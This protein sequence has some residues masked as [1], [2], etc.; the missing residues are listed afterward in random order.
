MVANQVDVRNLLPVR[1][2]N[3]YPVDIKVGATTF[4]DS[5]NVMPVEVLCRFKQCC[6]TRSPIARPFSR[7]VPVQASKSAS[8]AVGGIR[9]VVNDHAVPILS[10]LFVLGSEEGALVP[11]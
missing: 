7:I 4:P 1:R 5:C 2:A 10:V 6:C 11:K 9:T 8:V 3:H